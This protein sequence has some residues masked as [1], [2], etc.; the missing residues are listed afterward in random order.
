M[1]AV[2]RTERLTK[3]YGTHRGI[4]DVDLEV[5]DGRGLRVPGPERRRQDDDD[6]DP[7]GPDPADVRAGRSC[8]TSRSTVDPVSIHRRI[9][10]IPGEFALYDRLTGGQTIEYFG[11]LRGGV[12][13][14]Y[15]A[16]LV[17][18]FDLDPS[19]R[20]KEYSKGNKQKV[21]LVIALQ[22]RPEL[23]VLDE[24]TSGPRPAGPAVV[25]RA[26]P[27]GAGRGPDGVPVQPHPVRGRADLRPGRDHPRRDPGQGGQRRGAARPRPP[28]GGA[29][30]RR[31]R[32]R[33]GVRRACRACPTSMVEDHT[34]GCA[35]RA[36]SRRSSRRPRATSCSTSSAGSRPSRR[37]SWPS[38]ARRPWRS[39]ASVTARPGR[40]GRRRRAPVP[41]LRRVYGFGSIYG[42]TDPRLA[43]RVH[44]RRRP[45]RRDGA[46]DGRGDRDDLPDPGHADRGQQAR[47]RAC[48]PRWS[49]CSAT[50]R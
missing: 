12:D 28:R 2:I 44:H 3:S 43:A 16:S 27:R 30:L 31:R 47:R 46:R 6:P 17:E 29:A 45:A 48:R 21:G 14:A 37:R 13:P 25:L 18:R 39:K 7:A 5:A 15:R 36:R 22:H 24:P 38:T 23:L 40:R 26:R 4:V 19:R 9:G 35:S 34:C 32:P 10:Y 33:R 41:P 42:K 8:S 20:F 50:P 1:P 49:T 11:N